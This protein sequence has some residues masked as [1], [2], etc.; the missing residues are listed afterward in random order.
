MGD[1]GS[2]PVQAELA[3]MDEVKT[4]EFDCWELRICSVVPPLATTWPVLALLLAPEMLELSAPELLWPL[5]TLPGGA[6]LVLNTPVRL[7]CDKP[8]LAEL[9]APLAEVVPVLL[10]TGEEVLASKPLA[11]DVPL[12]TADRLQLTCLSM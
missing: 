9:A 10:S 1:Q 12:V 8:L 2:C 3:L 7:A 4:P 11:P 6:E 5:L